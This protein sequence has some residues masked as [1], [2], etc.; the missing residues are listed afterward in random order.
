MYSR[1]SKISSGGYYFETYH[2]YMRLVFMNHIILYIYP[3]MIFYD[4]C[5]W[6]DCQLHYYELC[7]AITSP[8]A[9]LHA[10][11]APSRSQASPATAASFA[12]CLRQISQLVIGCHRPSDDTFKSLRAEC[13]FPMCSRI[14]Q[15][16]GFY[17]GCLLKLN[18][19]F[20]LKLSSFWSQ[21]SLL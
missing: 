1:S 18:P 3:I 13:L 9:R 17:L 5:I 15:C 11:A 14:V 8:F 10:S 16:I 7:E 2:Y 4:L 6:I 19:F 21:P 20:S 12:S